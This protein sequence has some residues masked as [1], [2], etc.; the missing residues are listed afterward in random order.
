MKNAFLAAC[1]MCLCG[2]VPGSAKARDNLETIY[3]AK[4]GEIIILN[5][6]DLVKTT[7]GPENLKFFIFEKEY[8]PLVTGGQTLFIIGVDLAE[9]PGD[10]DFLIYCGVEIIF[11]GKITVLKTNFKTVRFK[12]VKT[13]PSVSI[14]RRI[15]EEDAAIQNAINSGENQ[16]I[17]FSRSFV[18][19]VQNPKVSCPAGNFGVYRKWLNG[20]ISRHGG[21]DL[22][23]QYVPIQAINDGTVVLTG[24]F[25]LEGKFVIIY[26]GLNI[27]SFYLHLSDICVQKSQ[28][29]KRSEKIG[30][31]GNTGFSK[32]AH[33]HFATRI[34]GK[35]IDPLKFVEA[36]NE[37][38]KHYKS[39]LLLTSPKIGV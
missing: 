25:L 24:N 21:I 12:S 3:A 1:L 27:Y 29:I 34:N 8:R 5:A 9:P 20:H 30:A 38:M 28:L 10:Y 33:L 13:T 7:V 14:A 35:I 6:L 11:K 23:A 36:I 15:V 37:Q 32:G 39:C 17:I 4:Q 16:K 22:K 26:H 31:S 2:A 18:C 19:P